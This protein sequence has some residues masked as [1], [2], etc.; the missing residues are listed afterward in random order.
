MAKFIETK[1]GSFVVSS[2]IAEVQQ[3]G[4]KCCSIRTKSG[5]HYSVP[6]CA[7]DLA[8]ELE[9]GS[10]LTIAAQ[11]G[12]FVIYAFPPIEEDDDWHTLLTPVVGWAA[13][14]NPE[15]HGF[16]FDSVPILAGMNMRADLW[17]LVWPDGSVSIPMLMHS[18]SVEE[19][20]DY[21]KSPRTKEHFR[22]SLAYSRV[23]AQRFE[24]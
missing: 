23:G 18:K 17:G 5:A 4:R 10:G 8:F 6:G 24:L 12:F 3:V 13:K 9:C 16:L 21:V 15:D 11:P 14:Q 19:W 2:E 7:R 22:E 1:D 20:L